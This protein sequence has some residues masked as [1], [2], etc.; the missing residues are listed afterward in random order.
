MTCTSGPSCHQSH[1]PA[2][3]GREVLSHA[4]PLARCKHFS[5]RQRTL[6][7]DSTFSCVITFTSSQTFCAAPFT[8]L[9]S[10]FWVSLMLRKTGARPLR[11]SMHFTAAS[12]RPWISSARI[13]VTGLSCCCRCRSISKARHEARGR[14][15]RHLATHFCVHFLDLLPHVMKR[16]RVEGIVLRSELRGRPWPQHPP[17]CGQEL[18]AVQMAVPQRIFHGSSTPAVLNIRVRTDGKQVGSG[19][20]PALAGSEMQ[21]EPPVVVALCA[22]AARSHSETVLGRRRFPEQAGIRDTRCCDRGQ[23]RS[24]DSRGFEALP[25]SDPLPRPSATAAAERHRQ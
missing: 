12:P 2:L 17:V 5:S 10:S 9:E 1:A 14:T 7:S 23:D 21:S 3:P 8:R 25:G 18:C 13:S 24:G 16:N 20:Q 15:S 4:C 22:T 6:I 11:A 19:Q